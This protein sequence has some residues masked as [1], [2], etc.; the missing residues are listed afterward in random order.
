MHWLLTAVLRFLAWSFGSESAMALR[1]GKRAPLG[2]DHRGGAA[3]KPGLNS[4]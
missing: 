1:P 3:R 4:L 2:L